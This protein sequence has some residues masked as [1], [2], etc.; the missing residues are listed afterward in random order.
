M[1]D[2]C[3]SRKR[4]GRDRELAAEAP[5]A[6]YS[7]RDRLGSIVQ[8]GKE[9]VACDHGK[10]IGRY[11]TAGEAANAVARRAAMEAV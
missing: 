8:H 9:F 3:D 5:R 10:S 6:I 7:G 4:S 1:P 2:N 11:D